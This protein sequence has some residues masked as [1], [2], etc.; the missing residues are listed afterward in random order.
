M[1]QLTTWRTLSACRVR[2]NAH[3]L[4]VLLLT[5]LAPASNLPHNYTQLFE[6]EYVRVIHAY[7]AP[8][9]KLPV[10]DHP[11]TPTVYVYLADAGPVRFTHTGDDAFS[12]NRPPVKAGGF[13]LSRG[14]EEVHAVENLSDRPNDF[15]RVELKKVPLGTES[16]SGRFPPPSALAANQT[17][18]EFE[19]AHIR[20]VRIICAT[21]KCEPHT[22]PDPALQIRLTASPNGTGLLHWVPA[23]SAA[24]PNNA[25]PSHEL[26]IEF[27]D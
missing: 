22:S 4:A 15:L 13:R 24:V 7:Y 9:E 11:K 20:I 23:N 25:A 5:P 21:H 18:T 14:R 1:L 19:D 16:L 27:K 2:T 10:H 3:A 17:K 12:L 6:N 26:R 8:H